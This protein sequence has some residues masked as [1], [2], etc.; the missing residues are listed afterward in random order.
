MVSC[1]H[2]V[3]LLLFFYIEPHIQLAFDICRYGP[4]LELDENDDTMG[5]WREVQQLKDDM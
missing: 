1:A 3:V 5:S 2:V 4:S